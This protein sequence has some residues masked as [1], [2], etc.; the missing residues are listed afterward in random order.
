[1]AF[2]ARGK[3]FPK[4]NGPARTQYCAGPRTVF[5]SEKRSA[6]SQG[7]F[8]V[9]HF[10][11]RASRFFLKIFFR[12]ALNVILSRL[13]TLKK[14]LILWFAL[15]AAIS[16]AEN[17]TV[18]S[19]GKDDGLPQSSVISLA[20]TPDGYL[21]LGTLNGLVRFDGNSFTHFNVANTP[22]LP[23]NGIIFLFEDS[24]SNLWIGTDTAQLCAIQNGVL[25]NFPTDAAD[26]K[27]TSAFEDQNGAVWF[28]TDQLNFFCFTNGFLN[29]K[30]AINFAQHELLIAR[31][32]HLMVPGK[33][34]MRWELKDGRVKK[35]RGSNLEKDFGA[36]PWNYMPVVG[37][38]NGGKDSIQSFD[39]NIT[40]AC[41]DP[42]GNLIVGTRDAGIFRTDSAG[43]WQNISAESGLAKNFILSIYPDRDGNLWIGTDPGGLYRVKK[44][45]FFSLT[46]SHPWVAQSVSEDLRGG[47]W[48][49]FNGRGLSYWLTNLQSDFGIGTYSNAW[50]VLV[51][52]RQ[53]VWAGTRGEGLFHYDFNS[54]TFQKILAAQKIGSQIFALFQ[55]RAGTIFVGG[56]NGFGTFDSTNWNF[57]SASD[58]LAKN[59]VRAFAEDAQSNLW[60]GTE[61]GLFELRDGKILPASAPVSDISCL[62]ADRDGNLW[63]GTFGH[64][65]ARLAQG[66]WKLC[67]SSDG[68]A[69]DDIGYLLEDDAGNLWFG[70]YEG[71]TRI[72]KNSLANFFNG[73]AKKIS[74]R[75]F[76]TRECAL[77]AQP[78]A[79]QTRDGKLL[80]PTIQGLVA[81]NPVDL[82]LN[83]NA[84]PVVIELV[85]VDGAEQKTNRLNSFWD[86]ALTVTPKNQ[87]LE[88]H[89]TS[90]DFSAPRR[91]QSSSRFRFRLEPRDKNWTD[92]G[93]ER[94]L[95][96]RV[97][98]LPSGKFIFR[99]S[100]CNEDGIWNETG[101][102]LAVNVLPPFWKT[103][104][105]LAATTLAIIFA[106]AGIIYLISTQK[107]K[108]QLRAAKQHELIERERARIARDL[109]DQLG[110][111]LTQVT[112]L[113]EMAETDKNS[114]DEVQAH[115]R[116]IS[117]TAR[118]TTH[119]LDE[120]VWAVNPANDTLEGLINYACKYAQDYFALAG[121][122]FRVDLPDDLPATPIA[123]DLRHNVFLAFKEAVNNV[124][125]HAHANEARVKLRLEPEQFILTIADNGRGFGEMDEKKLRN[126]LKNM[127]KRLAD[128][129]GEF[130]IAP[131]AN[132][133]TIVRLRVP[134]ENK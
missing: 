108:R 43:G 64:G 1:L 134:L 98:D 92:L 45:F 62:L 75:T 85:L 124:V 91:A 46:N 40:V 55:N 67:T 59:S 114:P 44:D 123:P 101:A 130:E 20:Q 110:A 133:G 79:I 35:L 53:Q 121:V 113:G 81:V 116:Q 127:R 61:N 88:I 6:C 17:F 36:T 87:Q 104:W 71:L 16:P 31:A 63:V 106:L 74:G 56:E 72:E 102:T 24:H 41:D 7:N 13:N 103:W 69:A 84:P 11:P 73:R 70:A 37:A 117:E 19:W 128:V 49:A 95:I 50:C 32:L 125:K 100:A 119:A 42:D 78:A 23:A 30:P 90:L 65:L 111:N 66:G 9:A 118:E 58:G 39:G 25:K 34:G 14:I 115:A 129:R 47:L 27:V 12:V 80:F 126:G 89:F 120:I 122:S 8:N 28:G 76:L 10:V 38:F 82:K 21:W 97:A 15:A 5:Q 99:V 112:L 93:N 107:L 77:G 86:W 94:V 52:H 2:G 33:N 26:G 132:G 48:T 4:R 109:H 105:F 131:G 18:D 57:F 22:D 51:D 3:F 83:S 96:F 60:I 68:L 29:P 54:Y